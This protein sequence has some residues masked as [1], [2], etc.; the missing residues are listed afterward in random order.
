M[1]ASNPIQILRMHILRIYIIMNVSVNCKQFFE[2]I[3]FFMKKIYEMIK[4]YV[5]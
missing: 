5:F 3:P 1:H 2:I 4:N